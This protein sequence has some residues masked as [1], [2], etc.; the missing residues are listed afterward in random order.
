MVS[1]SL[2]VMLNPSIIQTLIFISE[3]RGQASSYL[4]TD[5][6]DCKV[7][8]TTATCS[9]LKNQHACQNVVKMPMNNRSSSLTLPLW[10]FFGNSD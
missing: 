4:L 3:G 1:K 9:H 6:L 7:F 8:V 5:E 10:V 2:S